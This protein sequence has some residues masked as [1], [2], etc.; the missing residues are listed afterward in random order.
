[1]SFISKVLS[2]FSGQTSAK[3]TTASPDVRGPAARNAQVK[4]AFVQD[5]FLEVARLSFFGTAY[6]SP[7]KRWAV[8]CS[9]SDGKGNGGY[10]ESGNG[11]VVLVDLENDQ[12]STV[13]TS[14][15]RPFSAAVSDVGIFVVHD[16]GLGSALQADV[17][18]YNVA[19]KELYR[20]KFGAN[21]YS[22]GVSPCGRFLAAQ[23]CNAPKSP[24]ENLLE[25]HDVEQQKVVFS[26]HPS[27]AWSQHYS[28]DVIDGHL[29]K[30]W[31]KLDKLGRF[32]Y[33]PSGEFLDEQKYL[34]AQLSKGDYV[35]R[36]LAADKLLSSSPSQDAAGIVLRTAD[37]AL[38]QGA[39]DRTDWAAK[40]HRLRGEAFE[41]LKQPAN[42][43][44]A[45]ELA[46]SLNP[47]IGVKAKLSSL[48]KS[49]TSPKN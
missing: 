18:A 22:I 13:L 35:A 26:V 10:R 38:T 43:I 46:L 48:R 45:Y 15:A 2:A 30:L 6:T 17:I 21:V 31:V 24:D 37:E 14:V 3:T 16:C 34:E 12:V 23:T 33:S 32:A 20:R 7:N 47:K 44:A 42:A 4:N 40:A 29:K 19:G 1:M 11:Q 49:Q 39:K 8:G 36:I 28:F 5:G 41:V 27:T 25:V 9:D